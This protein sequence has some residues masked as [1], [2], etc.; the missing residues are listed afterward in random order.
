MP[1][2]LKPRPLP[3]LDK[4]APYVPGDS[5]LDGRDD[6]VKLS[7]N[8]SALGTS[9]A[10]R[11]A[12]IEAAGR[13]HLYPDGG[14]TALREAIGALHGIEPAQIVCGAGSDELLHLLGAGYVA[15]GDEV[16]YHRHGFLVYPLIAQQT[17]AIAVAAPERGLDADV[18]A[19]L[20]RVSERTK[21]VFL[22]NPS[23]PKG[24]ML[25]AS[26]VRRLHAGLPGS[27]I[28]ALDAAYAEF[29]TRKD[30]ESGLALA[31]EAQNVV[32]TRTFSKAYG[33]AG[34][35]LGWMY[36]PPEIV[37][38]VHRM[39]GPFNVSAPAIAAGV[40]ALKDQAFVARAVAHNE[41]ERTRVEAAAERL[42]ILAV[43]GVS[44]FVLLRFPDVAGKTARDADAFLR[45]RGVILRGM[46]AYGLPDCLRATVGTVEQ[47]GRLISA[48]E[49]F[50][51]ANDAAPV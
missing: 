10:A 46:V 37:D 45:A 12:Y 33:L 42:G 23:N 9:E 43:R 38:V 26:E 18:D 39:R 47:N 2:A 48:L 20:E 22:D 4:I 17:R 35:R 27:T 36:G 1:D 25:P 3:G 34:V 51:G 30:Y 41:A 44:N 49:W 28:L 29:V 6:V 40:A 24:T 19:L 7:S 13:L 5:R 50:M 32:V 11:A 14:A 15:P 31:R 21:I 8:E 16:L